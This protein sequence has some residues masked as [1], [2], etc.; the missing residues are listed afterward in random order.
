MQ[1]IVR[2]CP[3]CGER[4]ATVLFRAKAS[5]GPICKCR[6]C[7]MVYIELVEDTKSLIFDGPVSYA[8]DDTDL[9]TSSSLEKVQGWWEL[10]H[11]DEKEAELP[12]LRQNAIETLR[13]LEK[14]TGKPHEHRRLLDFGSGYGYFLSV[15]KELGWQTLG[16]EPLVGASVYARAKFGLM[17]KTD[18]L[19]EDTF[20]SDFFDVVTA[21]QVFEHIPDPGESLRYLRNSMKKDGTILIE[22]PRF[23][24]WS[25][26]LMRSRH[27][28]F[29]EDHLNFF[30]GQTLS[31]LLEDAGFEV[32]DQYQPARGMSIQ[33]LYSFWLSR[34]MPKSVA[35]AG[36]NVLK[37]INL[38][39]KGLKINIGDII[40][41][42]GRKK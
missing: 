7:Q 38:W 31:R 29:V 19:R 42:I 13:H 27:R 1:R 18:I 32:L 24:T 15:A 11:V 28:H 5:P 6:N 16:L 30:S 14:F 40:S 2:N 10:L 36:A 41:V 21:F 37:K 4:S 35:S 12:W 34:L 9:L 3:V 26:S 25:V 33:H 8:T 23:D 20:P 17:I 39:N 22:V